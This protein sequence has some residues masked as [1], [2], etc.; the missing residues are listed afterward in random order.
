[1]RPSSSRPDGA[2]VWAGTQFQT[3]DQGAI[4]QTLGIKTEQVNLIT[5]AGRRRLRPPRG[6]DIGLPA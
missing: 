3:V 6:A 4:A 5:L 2:T 1:M